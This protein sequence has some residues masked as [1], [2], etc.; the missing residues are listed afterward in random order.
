MLIVHH[1]SNTLVNSSNP[2]DHIL[3]VPMYDSSGHSDRVTSVCISPDGLKIVSGSKDNS[4]KIWN[5]E[6][7]DVIHTLQGKTIMTSYILY[8]AVVIQYLCTH[9]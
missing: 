9:I 6:T 8:K 2:Y 4:I 7:G 3:N 5:S 1:S